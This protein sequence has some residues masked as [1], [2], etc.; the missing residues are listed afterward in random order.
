MDACIARSGA[1]E[2]P[3][4]TILIELLAQITGRRCRRRVVAG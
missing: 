2:L 1:E 4:F 3:R